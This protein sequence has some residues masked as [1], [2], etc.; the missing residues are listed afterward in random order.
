MLKR[1]VLSMLIFSVCIAAA[2]SAVQAQGRYSN[3]YSRT[4]VDNFIRSLESSSDVFSRDF[5]NFGGTTTN[6]RR[7]VDRFENAVDR[8][9]SRFNSNNNWWASRT[10]VQGIMTEARQVNAMMNNA[11]YARPLEQQWRSLRR[12]IN[13][14]ADTYDLPDLAGQGGGNGGGWV[15]PGGGNVPSWAIGTF[16][17]RDSRTGSSLAMTVARNGSVT[18]S[19]DGNAPVYASLNGTTLNNGPYVSRL[20]RRG[21]G[22]RTTDVNTG[23]YIDYS[24]NGNGGGV[25]E[26]API[27]GKVPS[28]AVGQF[29][30]V[31]PQDGGSITLLIQSNGSVTIRQ[32]GGSPTYASINGTTLTNGPY[33]SRITRLSNGIRTTDV[34]N[35][36]YIDYYR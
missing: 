26:P 36:N 15:P 3:T 2:A 14:L 10:D 1:K 22:F 28:W 5:K 4:D 7:A 12:D 16:Y 35:G 33:V 34:N 31:S 27:G 17:G 11:R 25:I 6:E 30:G 20:S 13:K 8:L 21:D 24:R 23:E 29:S 18:I 32:N 9:R 19:V